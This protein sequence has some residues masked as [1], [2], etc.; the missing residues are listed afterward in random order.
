M[1]ESP[2]QADQAAGREDVRGLTLKKCVVCKKETRGI[3][4]SCGS[5]VH[6]ECFASHLEESPN[7]KVTSVTFCGA[8][9]ETLELKEL[10]TVPLERFLEIARGAGWERSCAS[11][12]HI[13]PKATE[14]SSIIE[15][16]GVNLLIQEAA[17]HSRVELEGHL[18]PLHFCPHDTKSIRT[19]LEILSWQAK[20]ESSHRR[21]PRES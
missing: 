14:R 3:C 2:E 15:K 5:P 4:G 20:F 11:V 8:S 21:V 9:V 1:P 19:A 6:P 18:I 12:K 13:L 17:G 7:C 16:D 10:P